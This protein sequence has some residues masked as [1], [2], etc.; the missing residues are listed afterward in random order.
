MAAV[1]A[2][3]S[4]LLLAAQVG[5]VGGPGDQAPSTQP[6]G[7]GWEQSFRAG[8]VNESAGEPIRGTEIV[9]LAAHKGRLY[10]G[11]GYWMDPRLPDIPWAQVLVLDSRD[12]TWKVDLALGP[13]HLRVTAL[14]S[15]TF[16]TDGDGKALATP[17]N[18]LLVASDSQGESHIWTRDDDRNRW[19]QT[20]LKGDPACRRSTRAFIV[21][22]DRQTG[23][24]RVFVATGALGIFSGVFDAAQPGKIRWDEKAELV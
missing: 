9:H 13:G 16:T 15:L 1:T 22:R 4:A 18:L 12:G 5:L 3:V 24:D 19:A 14:E 10:A 7:G 23:I 20:T 8:A 2:T 21:H 6:A 11:N 17:V